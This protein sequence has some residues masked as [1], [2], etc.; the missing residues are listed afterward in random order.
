ML[1]TFLYTCSPFVCLLWKKCLQVLCPFLYQVGFWV[2]LLWCCYWVVWSVLDS[3]TLSIIWF[4]NVLDVRDRGALSGLRAVGGELAR[5]RDVGG[6]NICQ[7]GHSF[8]RRGWRRS[9]QG[10]WFSVVLGFALLKKASASTWP[11]WGYISTC[12]PWGVATLGRGRCALWLTLLTSVV[13]TMGTRATA[14]STVSGG[15]PRAGVA[16]GPSQA[17]LTS[18]ACHFSPC[19]YFELQE[20]V[21]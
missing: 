1:S 5:E 20:Q 9:G 17:P 8:R 3:N 6:R 18:T 16:S 14:Q 13:G 19:Q 21:C 11:A 4:E 15:S 10:P 7:A 2:S 12:P